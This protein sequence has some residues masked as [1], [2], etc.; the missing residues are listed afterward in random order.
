[1][2][3]M[4]Q[5]QPW[6]QGTSSSSQQPACPSSSLQGAEVEITGVSSSSSS[7]TTR[8]QGTPSSSLQ[9]AC[10]SSTLQRQTSPK[11]SFSS[12]SSNGTRHGC[13]SLQQ[14]TSLS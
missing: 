11:L 3:A 5:L 7:S 10:P 12:N 13:H 8:Q 2:L 9:P 14:G 4:K 6:Q 1:V